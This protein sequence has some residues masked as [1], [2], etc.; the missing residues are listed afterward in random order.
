[1]KNIETKGIIIKVFLGVLLVPY[2]SHCTISHNVAVIGTGYVGSVLGACLASFN[3][4][5]ICVDTNKDIIAKLKR[6]EMTIYEPGLA[7]L[8]RT[9]TK[10]HC[11]SF[12]D[13]PASAIRASDIVFIAVGTPMTAEGSADLRAV[14]AVARTIGEN[15]NSYKII[16]TK[17]TVPIGTGAH[18][19]DII[20]RH[21]TG[22]QDFDV[23]SNPEFLR[24]GSSVY[25]FLYPDRIVI[26]AES[27]RPHQAIH[28]LYYPFHAQILLSCLPIEKV[29]KRLNTQLTPF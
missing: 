17:S 21:S 11:L 23:V 29:Q 10:S 2:T 27:Q 16:C 3:H 28:D 19:K 22:G 14:E 9:T 13:D 8:I 1:M 6:G 7:E 4:K 20:T 5:V 25:D 18:I 15:L 24:E 26:G 12:S